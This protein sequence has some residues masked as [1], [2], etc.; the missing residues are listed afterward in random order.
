MSTS[1]S[2]LLEHWP[3]SYGSMHR[4]CLEISLELL[5]FTFCDWFKLLLDIHLLTTT[6]IDCMVGVQWRKEGV[7]NWGPSCDIQVLIQVDLLISRKLS[8]LLQNE[9]GVVFVS[10][11][12]S[13]HTMMPNLQVVKFKEQNYKIA[14][15]P[16]NN[17]GLINRLLICVVSTKEVELLTLV[18]LNNHRFAS[19][20]IWFSNSTWSSWSKFQINETTSI[21][22]NNHQFIVYNNYYWGS[23][24]NKWHGVLKAFQVKTKCPNTWTLCYTKREVPL[25]SFWY[26]F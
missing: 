7:G 8:N 20:T 24:L 9:F 18:S 4:G 3:Q 19:M 21:V 17:L 11:Q 26:W 1:W 6:H 23:A 2:H 12:N 14:L 13:M 25:C 15:S 10:I 5:K 22:F 16:H